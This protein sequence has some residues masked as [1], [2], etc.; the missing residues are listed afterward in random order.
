MCLSDY[1]PITVSGCFPDECVQPIVAVAA[2]DFTGVFERSLHI[3]NFS[4]TDLRCA[5][6]QLRQTQRL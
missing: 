6:D 3:H 4:V 1:R 5:A 2:Y